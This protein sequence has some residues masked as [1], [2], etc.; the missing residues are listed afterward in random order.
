M[1]TVKTAPAIELSPEDVG[2]NTSN[3]PH[4]SDLLGTPVSRRQALLGGR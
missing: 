3:N 1:D 4:L 2:T